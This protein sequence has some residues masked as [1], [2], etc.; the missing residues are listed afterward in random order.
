MSLQK[1]PLLTIIVIISCKTFSVPINKIDFI[2]VETGAIFSDCRKWRY[3]LWR[4]WNERL[5]RVMFIGL[6]PS[7]ADEVNNDAT[8]NRCMKLA[9]LWGF[10]GIYMLNLFALIDT[11]PKII[12]YHTDP[13]GVENNKYLMEYAGKVD[14]V[15]GVWGNGGAYSGRGNEVMRMFPEMYCLK[16]TKKNQPHHPLYLKLNIGYRKIVGCSGSPNP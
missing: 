11:N 6:N 8:I 7:I 2:P 10:G 12:K 1:T 14:L 3:A 13:I 5:R 9:G 15:I 4:I 16:M